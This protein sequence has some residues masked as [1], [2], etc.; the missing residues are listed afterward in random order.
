[1]SAF[2]STTRAFLVSMCDAARVLQ[3]TKSI[4]LS[5]QFDIV[6]NVVRQGAGCK[7]AK[8]FARA[9]RSM[10]GAA[11]EIRNLLYSMCEFSRATAWARDLPSIGP[12]HAMEV[13]LSVDL[14]EMPVVDDVWR[15]AGLDNSCKSLSRSAAELLL[16]RVIPPSRIKERGWYTREDIFVLAKEA[17]RNPGRYTG[18]FPAPRYRVLAW[19]LEPPFMSRLRAVCNQIGESIVSGDDILHR[20]YELYLQIENKRNDSG[21]LAEVARRWLAGHPD[22]PREEAAVY[23]TG[24]LP[25]SHVISRARKAATRGF[26]TSF[27][28]LLREDKAATPPPTKAPVSAME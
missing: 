7:D 23:L 14:A 25:Q 10:S 8:C 24:K 6:Q 20:S 1:M 5:V 16:D 3:D 15:A 2:D 27:H 4:P 22:M 9:Y 21:Q 18:P 13:Y 26:L 28:E 11:M 12:V 19:L 17:G